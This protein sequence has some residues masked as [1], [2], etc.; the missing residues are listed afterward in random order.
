MSSARYD[1]GTLVSTVADA[2]VVTISNA[3]PAV[4]TLTGHGW[5]NGDL[6]CFRS[7][8]G[9]LPS[10]INADLPYFVIAKTANTFE[11]STNPGGTA[12]NTTT[13]GSGTFHAYVAD[14]RMVSAAVYTSVPS[15]LIGRIIAFLSNITSGYTT[16]TEIAVATPAVVSAI[17][18]NGGRFALQGRNQGSMIPSVNTSVS[19]SGFPFPLTYVANSDGS[20]NDYGGQGN[21]SLRLNSL[22]VTNT[23]AIANGG[24]GQITKAAAFNALSPITSTGDLIVGTGTNT[25]GRLG[26][27]STGN[28]L[29]VAAG[30]ASWVA[31]AAAPTLSSLGIRAGQTTISS[32]STSQSVTFST[33]LGTTSY[34]VTATIANTT[35]AN[36]AYIP[37]T[38]TAQSA[39]AFT[40]SWNEPTVTANYVLNWTAIVNN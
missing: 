25:A 10:P 31:P 5:V 24:T 30:T 1:D 36:P 7:V 13:A 12:I 27:G 26:I 33:S 2:P 23:L 15:R 34:A 21:Q 14:S 20:I 40:A 32:A 11:I 18:P 35:D 9:T 3:S 16:P 39:T 8:G 29:T 22:A 37:V 19:T 28:V 38:I 17:S 4:I 6:V